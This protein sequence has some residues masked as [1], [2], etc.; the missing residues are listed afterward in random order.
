VD[1]FVLVKF[2]QLVLIFIHVSFDTLGFPLMVVVLGL[3]LGGI[4]KAFPEIHYILKYIG[5]AYLLFLSWK[6][7]TIKQ[8]DYV[9]P[10]SERNEPYALS[11]TSM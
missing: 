11:E 9:T 8:Q 2:P 7:A 10:F 3:G 5:A 1:I 4:F 6:I